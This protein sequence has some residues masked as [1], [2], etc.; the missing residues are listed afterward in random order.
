MTMNKVKEA[1]RTIMEF[2]EQEVECDLCP[3]FNDGNC[4]IM[5][6][7]PCDWDIIAKE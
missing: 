6:N 3:V 5:Y 1:L 7:A 2:C 4:Q